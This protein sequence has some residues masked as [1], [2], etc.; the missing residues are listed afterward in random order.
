MFVGVPF[1]TTLI[2]FVPTSLVSYTKI[3]IN[4]IS[5]IHAGGPMRNNELG[6]YMGITSSQ[7]GQ[8]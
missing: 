4:S 8:V 7:A 3:K 1:I 6:P 5:E 2:W